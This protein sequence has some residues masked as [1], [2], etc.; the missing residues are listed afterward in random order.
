M[1]TVQDLLASPTQSS[2][3][4]K[5]WEPAL[6]SYLLWRT[7]LRDAYAVL[8]GNAVAIRQTTKADVGIK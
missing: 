4:G 2:P 5:H 1:M 6:P 8:K 7:R 3:D